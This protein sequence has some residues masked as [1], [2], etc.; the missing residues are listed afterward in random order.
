MRIAQSIAVWVFWISCGVV[1]YTYVLYP[2]ILFIMYASA[3]LRRDVVYLLGRR[4]RRAARLPEE[5]L[6]SVTLVMAAYNEE[7]HLADK[8]A[9]IGALDYPREKFEV[10]CVSDGSTDRTN[11]I[12]QSAAAKDIRRIF[13]EKRGGKPGALNCAVAAA[14]HNIIVFSDASTLFEPDAV[15]KLVRHFSDSRVGAVCGSVKFRSSKES[16][17]TEGIY[18]RFESILRLMEARLGATLTASG[19]IYALRREAYQPL[20]A[21][22]VLDDFVVPMNSRR[23]GYGIQYDPE[24]IALEFAAETIAGE[25]KR[26]VRLATGSFTVLADFLRIRLNPMTVFA[27]FSHKI[28]RWFVPF[29]L[30]ALLSSNLL[31]FRGGYQLFLLMQVLF[32]LWAALGFVFHDRMERVP[33]ALLGYFLFA[34]NFAFLVGFFR[35]VAGSRDVRWERVD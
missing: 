15:R 26:R 12:L 19:A 27:F 9:N 7:L 34:M 3:Q 6:P 31:L 22:A 23:L 14:R 10:I 5:N 30:V 13:L 29:F 17:Q 11:E 33:Y 20:A 24:A 25:F 18:W 1:I 32:Y 8:L 2:I 28:C 4:D 35:F 16:E 21:D